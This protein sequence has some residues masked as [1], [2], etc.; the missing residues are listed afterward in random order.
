MSQSV[1][2]EIIAIG[3]EILLGEITDTN[4]VFIARQ[5][6]DYGIN[7]YYMTS[8]GDNRHR[9]ADAIRIAMSRAQVVITCGGLGPTVD[10]MTR[11]AVADATGRELEFRQE[12]LDQIAAR[13]ATFRVQ[14]TENNRQQAYLPQGSIALENP[15]GTAPSFIVNHNEVDVISL[16]GVPREM[17]YLF[18]EKVVPYLR[19]KYQLGVIK[20][21]VLKTAGIGESMLDSMIGRELL[22]GANPT[23]GLA[24]HSGQVDVRITAKAD[25]VEE[26]M[27]SIARIEQELMGRI[28]KHVYG[29]DEDRL[30]RVLADNLKSVGKKIAII[31]AGTGGNVGRLMNGTDESVVALTQTYNHPDQLGHDIKAGAG[32]SLR[33]LAQAAVMYVMDASD[34]DIGIAIM[35][36]PDVNEGA[37]ANESTAVLVRSHDKTRSRVF[38][39]G[40]QAD[41]APRWISM[42]ALSAAWGILRE[43]ANV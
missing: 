42:W 26:A 19:Q 1:N 39:F 32:F 16:P 4:S 37:D 20:A 23:V 18:T 34:A 12:L 24:A 7:L 28:G 10:D 5:L 43:D 11:I 2:A 27:V 29:H 13:F 3:T 8:V 25:T 22:E 6:R 17:K 40:G 9:I 35:T 33:D 31:E 30:E 14:M 21:R 41:F 38:G 15:V 36:N